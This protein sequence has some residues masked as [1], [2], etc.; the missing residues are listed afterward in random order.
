[1]KQIFTSLLAI[2]LL[3]SACK[4]EQDIVDPDQPGTPTGTTNQPGTPTEVGK[5]IGAATSQSIGPE[6][7]SITASDGK[8]TLTIPAG[9]LAK[10]TVISVEP[11]ENTVGIGVGT[12]YHFMPEGTQFAKPATF[13]YHYTDEDMNGADMDHFAVAV[14]QPDRSWVVTHQATVDKTQRTITTQIRHFSWWS[15]VTQ[16]KLSASASEVIPGQQA[17]LTVDYSETGFDAKTSDDD[18]IVPIYRTAD[19]KAIGNCTVNGEL[20][21]TSQSGTFHLNFG[22]NQKARYLYTAPATLPAKSKRIVALGVELDHAGPGKL[23]LVYNMPIVSP[24]QLNIDGTNYQEVSASA[25]VQLDEGSPSYIGVELSELT[26]SAKI[27]RVGVTMLKGFTGVGTYTLMGNV[28]E[29]EITTFTVGGTSADGKTD[30]GNYYIESTGAGINEVFAPATLKIDR[31]DR[32]DKIVSGTISCTLY[33]DRKKG[34]DVKITAKFRS[35]VPT[36]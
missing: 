13:T 32:F 21:G 6:G 36:L 7:G 14:Q 34:T 35:L 1:M 23:M 25:S 16:Y 19:L 15:L 4:K 26:K 11:V 20:F 27:T 17:I 9:A 18:L 29:H 22:E 8:L 28:G 3:I 31:I 12:G 10:T 30:Y 2:I 24:A 5:P 33:K